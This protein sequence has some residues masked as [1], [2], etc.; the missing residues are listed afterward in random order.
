[1]DIDTLLQISKMAMKAL[2]NREDVAIERG[3]AA[4]SD[5]DG[6]VDAISLDGG[7]YMIYPNRWSPH[8]KN[9]P[10]IQETFFV[11]LVTITPATRWDPESVDSEIVYG[12]TSFIDALRYALLDMMKCSINSCFEYL[13]ELMEENDG[14]Q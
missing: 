8:T 11:D 4:N 2:M 5:G 9:G 13:Y 6:F 1:M 12:S 10:D 7:Q 3:Y 14:L